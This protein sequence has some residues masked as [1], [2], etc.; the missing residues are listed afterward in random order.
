MNATRS[1]GGTSAPSGRLGVVVARGPDPFDPPEDW[2]EDDPWEPKPPALSLA[3]EVVYPEPEP[4]GPRTWTVKKAPLAWRL[5]N[6]LRMLVCGELFVGVAIWCLLACRS[7]A[8]QRIPIF[9][10]M[11]AG[12]FGSLMVG[13]AE[14]WGVVQYKDGTLDR[15]LLGRHLVVTAGKNY[16]AACM[17]NTSEPE[18]L[19][20]HGFG[21]GTT[22]AAAG[23]TALQT[24]LTTQYA[25]DNTRP[26]GSQAHSTNTY[27]TV[28]TLSPDANVAITEWGLLTQAA[29]GGGTMLDHQVFSAVNLA[30]SADS[31]TTTYV[32]TFS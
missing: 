32:L 22:A 26:T 17:D 7:K 8:V 14:L 24:E 5:R 1:I 4:D 18:N 20:Y 3:A 23:D 19:K 2:T 16:L 30:A 31:L 11:I 27:T 12:S 13:K 6:W 21:T 9:G 29:T 25:T 15:R 28:A 10:R